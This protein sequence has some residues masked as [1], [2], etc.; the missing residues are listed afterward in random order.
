[1]KRSYKTRKDVGE[2]LPGT[3]EPWVAAPAIL[4]GTDKLI[5]QSPSSLDSS[6]FKVYYKNGS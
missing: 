5:C 1:M 2:K 4:A 3:K 6:L